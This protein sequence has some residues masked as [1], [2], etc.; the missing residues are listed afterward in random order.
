MLPVTTA[1]NILV[2][3]GA[4]NMLVVIT[5]VNMLVVVNMLVTTAVNMLVAGDV[6]KSAFE[7]TECSGS[8]RCTYVPYACV[9]LTPPC[10]L[11]QRV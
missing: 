10:P 1:V 4:V 6:N 11:T 3:T 9:P 8:P 7:H 2:V 5:A